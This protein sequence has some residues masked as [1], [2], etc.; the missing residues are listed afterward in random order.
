MLLRARFTNTTSE[1]KSNFLVT[2]TSTPGPT[3]YIQLRISPLS[4]PL[5]NLATG[6]SSYPSKS[7][8]RLVMMPASTDMVIISQLLLLLLLQLRA[9]GLWALRIH[10]WVQC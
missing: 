9:K 5:S 2:T 10:F 6:L 8:F 7:T 4:S 1:Y 3:S